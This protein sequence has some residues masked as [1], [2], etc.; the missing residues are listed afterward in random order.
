[1][2]AV[3]DG[4]APGAARTSGPRRRRRHRQQGRARRPARVGVRRRRRGAGPVVD[5]VPCRRPPRP[6]ARRRAP[7][8][9]GSG[10]STTTPTPLPTRWPSCSPRPPPT[11]RPTCSAPS[12]ASG[13]RCAGCSRWASPSRAPAAARPGSSAAS[14]TRAS[15]TTY[16]RVLAVNTA[17]MLVRRSVLEDLGGFDDQL[18]VFGNDI[19][20]GW[21]AAA[22]GHKT[23]VVP[24]AVVFHVEA[25][26]RGVRR[27]PLTGRHTHYQERRAALYTLLVNTRGRSLPVAG[28][29]ARAGHPAAGRRLP[30]GPGGRAGARR[31]GRP[32]LALRQPRPDRG[33]APRAGAPRPRD[34]RTTSAGCWRP[35]G[36]PTGTASTWSATSVTALT[37]P[38]P[39]R[40]RTPPGGRRGRRGRAPGHAAP[41]RATTT[42]DEDEGPAADTGMV[43]RFLTNPVAVGVALFVLLVLFGAREA[44]GPVSGGGLSA[45]PA[46]ARDLWQ[47]YDR[48]VARAGPGHG[49]AR[50]AVRAAARDARHRSWAGASPP[51]S[52]RSCCWRSRW[53]CGAP[54]GSCASSVTSAT[55]PARRAG[56]WPWRRPPTHWS[57]SS[58]APGVTAASASS[59]SR[60]CCP[61]WGT[62]PSASPIPSPTG[63]GAPPGGPVCCWRW[64]RP[65]RRWPGSSPPRSGWLMVGVGFG[66]APALMRDRSVWGPPAAMLAPCPCCCSPW[67]LPGGRA[68]RRRQPA[69]R[70]R[71]AARPDLGFARPAGRPAARRPRRA[72]V[73]RRRAGR[74]GRARADP[75][76]H[77]HPRARGV[78]GGAGRGGHLG[79]LGRG[80]PHLPVG[81]ARPG[82]GFFL[83]VLRGAFVV[84]AF[85]AIHGLATRARRPAPA[86]TPGAGRADRGRGGDPGA[87][88][89]VVRARGPGRADRRPRHRHPGVHGAGRARAGRPTASWSSAAASRTA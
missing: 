73:A 84:A 43:A 22:A 47:L 64:S 20:F 60:P 74:D 30:A 7:A 26:H 32:G 67:W 11:P 18:A 68:R 13:P 88:A 40:R 3:G 71:P 53:R 57:R 17:G 1:M 83:V 35:G 6:G 36:C 10:S 80:R 27:T 14:T 4:R 85:I 19:D 72:V 9:S 5:V 79:A 54:G 65:S 86:A 51:R 8:P 87:G 81:E 76:A 39:G 70:L 55:P 59:S 12:C 28:G 31:A 44:I 78:G 61:G 75:V 49:R 21:R 29:P 25:A 66:I 62:P 46:D 2:A 38:G 52:R 41:A 56:C 45:A 89:G 48:V 16:A 77:P 42:G 15:T 58:A 23:I 24:S 82:L 34:R 63:A 69:A 50:A 33:R 37:L